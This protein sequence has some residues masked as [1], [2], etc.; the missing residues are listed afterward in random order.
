MKKF[1]VIGVKSGNPQGMS[2][3]NIAVKTEA[4]KLEKSEKS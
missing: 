4:G 3:M 2:E 1:L